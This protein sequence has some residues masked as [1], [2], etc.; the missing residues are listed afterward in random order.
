MKISIVEVGMGGIQLFGSE[1]LLNLMEYKKSKFYQ[2]DK[3]KELEIALEK[4][5]MEEGEPLY[6]VFC[7]IGSD[8]PI[9][10]DFIDRWEKTFCDIPLPWNPP[11]CSTKFM[12]SDEYIKTVDG[13]SKISELFEEYNSDNKFKHHIPLE[14]GKGIPAR[15]VN[16]QKFT[17]YGGNVYK[18]ILSEEQ[19]SVW[20]APWLNVKFKEGKEK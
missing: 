12:I 4:T 6:G 20:L 10:R 2:Y 5:E 11:F 17:K 3:K 9:Y 1:G 15:I 18:M 19:E 8:D 14:T 7:E 13:Y 16:I